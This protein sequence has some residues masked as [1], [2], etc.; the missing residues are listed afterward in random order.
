MSYVSVPIGD[1]TNSVVGVVGVV[2]GGQ[3]AKMLVEASK[4]RNVD[5]FVQT[6]SL[7]DPAALNATRLVLAEAEDA[8]GTMQ[9]VRQCSAVTF[10]N[11]WVNIEALMKLENQGGCFIPSLASLKPLVD[12]LSQRQLLDELQIP[13]PEWIPLCSDQIVDFKLPIGW[14]YPL[15]AKSGRGGYDGKG[16]R[17]IKNTQ[18]F[19][20]L[21][22]DVDPKNWL[23]EKWV[24]YEKE[25]ALVASR[26]LQGRIRTFPLAE[27]HQHQQVCDWVLAPAQVSHSV[28]MMAYNIVASLLTHLN[29][30]GVIAI[31]FFYGPK[32][33]MVNEV[34]P[35]T[36]NSAHFSIEACRSSQFDQQLCI[37]AGIEV[38]EPELIV[39]GA[40]MANLLGLPSEVS[41]SIEDRLSKLKKIPG[42]HVHWYGKA[43]EIPGRKLGHVTLLLSG[44]D[45]LS[46][47]EEAIRGL[48]NIRSIWPIV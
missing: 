10:E 29:Y 12:K 36:H 14:N 16:T 22:D 27:T 1:Q 31:E 11:E 19:S 40:L 20:R 39:P 26:D 18:E 45:S 41:S 9:L 2:G 17:V 15:M 6:K 42:A 37:A 30:V 35:R 28:Q 21:I 44:S 4:A 3:L 33:L 46:R 38:Q 25:L 47:S 43:N 32:G 7:E 8:S 48:E 24:P 13:G 34:A 23:L 5:I